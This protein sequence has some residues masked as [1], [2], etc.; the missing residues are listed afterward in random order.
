M[1][2]QVGVTSMDLAI[3]LAIINKFLGNLEKIA[4]TEAGKKS[5]LWL[6]YVNYVL[7]IWPDGEEE[8]LSFLNFLNQ[9]HLKV[10]FTTKNKIIFLDILLIKKGH[11]ANPKKTN[12]KYI[13]TRSHTTIRHNYH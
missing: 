12:I 7:E 9:I 3:S 13:S 6:R 11:T 8:I 5:S 2:K 10:K 1:N 4:V